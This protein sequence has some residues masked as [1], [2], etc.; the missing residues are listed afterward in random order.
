MKQYLFVILKQFL[1]IKKVIFYYDGLAKKISRLHQMRSQTKEVFSLFCLW[2]TRT[3]SPVFL[4]KQR[5]AQ[6]SQVKS[7]IDSFFFF[8]LVMGKMLRLASW[9]NQPKSVLCISTFDKPEGD[10]KMW[11]CL[12]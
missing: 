8:L 4:Y 11:A 3:G 7:R 9:S 10:S 1:T 2:G 5:L 6:T 12:V